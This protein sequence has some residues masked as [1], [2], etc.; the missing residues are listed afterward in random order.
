MSGQLEKRLKERINN[1]GG[2]SLREA[3]KS[4]GV[5]FN[6]LARMRRGDYESRS[7]RSF[8]LACAWAGV[9]PFNALDPLSPT[10]PASPEG[11]TTI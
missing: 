8:L 9:H 6:T 4:S 2:C 10:E 3:S 11:D 7:V 1:I 5:S